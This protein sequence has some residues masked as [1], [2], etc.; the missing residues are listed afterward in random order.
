MG[1][2]SWDEAVGN[3]TTSANA[4]TQLASGV[5]NLAPLA[6]TI[7]APAPS[8]AYPTYAPPA[9]SGQGAI[10]GALHFIEHV[11]LGIGHMAG[12]AEQWLYHNAVP[13]VEAP[14]KA[15]AGLAHAYL[16]NQQLD[17]INKESQASAGRLDTLMNQYKA[18]LITR[19]QYQQGLKGINQ[20]NANLINETKAANNQISKDYTD[21]RAAVVDTAAT[22]LTVLTAGFGAAPETLLTSSGLEANLG[23]KTAAQW[24]VGKGAEPFLGK[25]GD[26][27]AS[28]GPSGILDHLSPNAVK[29]VDRAMA[30]TTYQGTSL[31][32]GQIAKTTAANVALKYP[33]LYNY[34]DGNAQ[35][36]YKQLETGNYGQAVRQL[37]LFSAIPIAGGLFGHAALRAAGSGY[38]TMV[39]KVFPRSQ[40]VDTL[41]K[42]LF[43]N[44]RALYDAVYQA[45]PASAKVWSQG[46][47]DLEATHM[48]VTNN[49]SVGAAWNVI[50]GEKAVDGV[51]AAD[52]GAAGWLEHNANWAQASKE[53]GAAAEKAG[54]GPVV[55]VRWTAPQAKAASEALL[56]GTN[57]KQWQDIWEGLKAKYPNSAM[58]NNQNLEQQMQYLFKN[59]KT[60]EEL[61][62]K[63]NDIPAARFA[64]GIDK[65]VAEK[66]AQ[67]GFI[68]GVID[69]IKTPYKEGVGKLSSKFAASGEDFFT[70]AVAPLPVL[71]PLGKALTA[72][73]M[74]PYA[75]LEATTQIFNHNLTESLSN[76]SLV[77]KVGEWLNQRNLVDVKTAAALAGQ[78]VPE[79]VADLSKKK[80]VDFIDKTISDYAKAPSSGFMKNVALQDRRF[81]TTTDFKRAFD[82]K[83]ISITGAEAK[84]LQNAITD[85]HWKVDMA[86]KGMGEKAV[87]LLYKTKG[88]NAVVRRFLRFQNN[89]RY[90]VNPFFQYGRAV[91][92]LEILSEA[93]GGGV[94]RSLFGNRLKE[95]NQTVRDLK[96][97][98]FLEET[99]HL[100]QV[101]TDEA[102]AYAG[103][104]D[105]NL[106]KKLLPM[107][108]KSIGGLVD[109]LAQKEGITAKEYMALHPDET[110]NL[111]QSIA[112]YSHTSDFLNSPLARTLNIAFFPFRFETKVLQIM[113]KSLAGASLF[114][115]V[116]VINGVINAHRFLNSPQ[117]TAWY[118][119][120]ADA[121]GL[122]KYISPV[123]ELNQVFNS[124]LPGHDHHV[125]NFGE[126]GGL[127]FGFI[128]QLT[129]SEGWTHFNQV[130]VDA[131]TGAVIPQ[132]IPATARGQVATAI[133][134]F[135][136][137]MFSYPGATAGLP[138]KGS[139]TRQAALD[140][141]F[142]NKKTDLKLT[143]PPASALSPQAQI[144]AA[145]LKELNPS[146]GQVPAASPLPPGVSAPAQPGAPALTIP[147][148]YETRVRSGGSGKRKKASFTPQLLPGQTAP[149][150]AL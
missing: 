52:K 131:K 117:G 92:K 113:G 126:L 27:I 57:T 64:N 4:P 55:A 85:A 40:F 104:S 109:A 39:G 19:S 146:N 106:M 49:D 53:L 97:A 35:A 148:Q 114:T 59:S 8:P 20:D 142:G 120:N 61:A 72:V 70:K 33:L 2:L 71:Q 54:L 66:W 37:A 73:G 134:D 95:M 11:G 119:A 62:G 3:I 96:T 44:E 46:L 116:A 128:P 12:G 124:L 87:D 133:Q 43:G 14:F 36:F 83:G 86:F 7:H 67:K 16:D 115:K 34:I 138:S 149:L 48:A 118:S 15:G 80:V 47:K 88:V 63:V 25:I 45:D 132:Y 136:S 69:N 50:N 144:Y 129:D 5:A 32:A 41:S 24:L 111:I 94:L 6:Q 145:R 42:G 98:G 79:K 108:E 78:D 10:P 107:Q 100:G 101:I 17:S 31:T 77:G 58:S 125:G 102:V 137:S 30:E 9:S 112:E 140:L 13:M 60:G 89:F 68:P 82:K 38:S 22:L 141:T 26:Y 121:I 51:N 29:W 123:A 122:F 103:A 139:I 84:E 74:S 143:T 81:M 90:G 130:G 28:E 1:G 93:S 18:G 135:L 127:P 147:N 76:S 21:A 56:Q 65:A 23:A 105:K 91:P 99:G 75:S 110:K 150:G